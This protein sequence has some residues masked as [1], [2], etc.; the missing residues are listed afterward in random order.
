MVVVVVLSTASAAVATS[1][2]PSPPRSMANAG[3]ATAAVRATAPIATVLALRRVLRG[4][5]FGVIGEAPSEQ[6]ATDLQQTAPYAEAPV[7]EMQR[8]VT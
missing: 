1:T 5:V 4:V 2:A 8:S 6:T 7:T 3:S